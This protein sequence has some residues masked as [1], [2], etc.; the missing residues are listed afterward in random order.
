MIKLRLMRRP[1][2]EAE[3]EAGPHDI[4]VKTTSNQFS[5]ERLKLQLD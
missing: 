4:N 5:K 3:A 2:N 1:L